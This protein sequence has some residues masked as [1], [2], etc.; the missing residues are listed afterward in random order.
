MRVEPGGMFEALLPTGRYR[1]EVHG[2]RGTWTRP[3]P[4]VADAPGARLYVPLE[5]P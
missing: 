4:L 1:V 3:A 5:S 2:L